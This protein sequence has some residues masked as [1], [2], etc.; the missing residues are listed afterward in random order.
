VKPNIE[1]E[2][3]SQRGQISIIT[4]KEHKGSAQQRLKRKREG[5]TVKEAGKVVGIQLHG[6]R[7][8]RGEM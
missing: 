8:W 6:L 1:M 3:L 7:Q 4:L 5:N 2:R